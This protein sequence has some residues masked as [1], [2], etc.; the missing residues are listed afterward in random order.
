[1]D[2]LR[3][4]FHIN[5]TDNYKDVVFLAG[6]GRSGTTWV[7]NIINYKNDYR[8]LFEPFF[9]KRVEEVTEFKYIQY[10]DYSSKN[11]T[12]YKKLENSALKILSGAV[13]DE[14]VDQINKNNNSDKLLIKTIRANL[15][16]KWLKDLKS[17][18]KMIVIIRHP[19]AVA[20]SWMKLGWGKDTKKTKNDLNVITSQSELFNSYPKLKKA[21]SIVD[22]NDM[23]ERIVFQWGVF[24]YVPFKQLEKN[25]FYLVAYEDLVTRPDNE[26]QNLFNYINVSFNNTDTNKL[27]KVLRRGSSTNF[28]KRNI[29]ED[30]DMMLA[31]W[32]K[33]FNEDQIKKSNKILEILDLAHIYN[34]NCEP[35]FSTL[36]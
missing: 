4:I 10:I 11:K 21:L 7:S 6:M 9:P 2:F 32:K 17:E 30:K 23:F 36:Y 25:D 14:W 35:D 19:L 33:Y 15:M 29:S 26:V 28:L 8:M 12:K 1:M 24:Y 16:L 20:A 3:K 5:S 13:S 31:G 27:N 22:K 34:K 18:I